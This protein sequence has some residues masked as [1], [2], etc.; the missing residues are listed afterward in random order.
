LLRPRCIY[1]EIRKF[2][3]LFEGHLA[4]QP[5]THFRL[6]YAVAVHGSGDLLRRSA[7][8]HDQAV[9]PLVATGL[10]E[11]GAFD[12]RDAPRLPLGIF[13]HHLFFTRD[14]G[15]MDQRIETRKGLWVGK[16]AGCEPPAVNSSILDY[17]SAK[18]LHH[19]LE[20]LAPRSQYR[21]PQFVRL[22]QEASAIGEGLS[23]ETLAAGKASRKPDF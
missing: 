7:G 20:S 6:A 17:I 2:S 9:E 22:D 10:N 16:H 13:I 19:G 1:D 21:V 3:F 8:D 23:D 5:R 12:N 15:R 11:D 4:T 14:H 18:F